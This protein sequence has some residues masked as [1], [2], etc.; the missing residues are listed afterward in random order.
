MGGLVA[1]LLLG[2][3]GGW[4][5]FRVARSSSHASASATPAES[6]V[7]RPIETKSQEA[8]EEIPEAEPEQDA[9]G[10]PVPGFSDDFDTRLSPA[11]AVIFGDPFIANGQL[12]SN[13]GAGIAAGDA[14]WENYQIDFDVDTSRIDCTFVDT[15]NSVGVRV[16]DFDHAY[17]FVFTDCNAGW[18]HI[19]GGVDQG[20][21]NLVPDTDVSTSKGKKHLTIKVEETKMSAYENGKLLS[22]IIDTSLRTGGIFLQVEAKTYYDNFQ[23]TLSP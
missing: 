13:L 22:A 7:P 20:A 23:V 21:P 19:A 14:S 10:S 11:W 6:S 8:P 1:I 16:K 12:T 3:L 5:L 4:Y 2:A 18:S 15:S 17:W 9:P